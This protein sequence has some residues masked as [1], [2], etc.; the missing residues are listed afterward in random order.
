MTWMWRVSATW[1]KSPEENLYI[2]T[3]HA[4]WMICAYR[5]E[6]GWRRLKVIV[7]V[8]TA[9][10]SM[11]NGGSAFSGAMEMPSTSRS[12]ITTEFNHGC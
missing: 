10:V 9:S 6:T 5:R 7:Q 1:K 2:Y 8:N 12:S 3:A 11:L 4:G